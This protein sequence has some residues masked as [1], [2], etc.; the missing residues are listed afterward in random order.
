MSEKS[1]VAVLVFAWILCTHSYSAAQNAVTSGTIKVSLE[2]AT[3]TLHE[4]A[5]VDVALNAPSSS[6]VDFD[7]G[8]DYDKI[9]VTIVDPQGRASSKLRPGLRNGGQFSQA[10]HVEAGR[11]TVLSFVLNEWFNFDSV[12]EYQVDFTLLS[13]E[14]PAS[15]GPRNLRTRLALTV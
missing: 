12:G 14:N 4:P 11:T 8:Y 7:P 3:I 9:A 13:Q 5:I 2:K 1:K 15:D 10:I 6:G